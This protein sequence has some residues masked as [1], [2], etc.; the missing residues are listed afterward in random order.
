M[1][2]IRDDTPR[3][4]GHRPKR[5][6]WYRCKVGEPVH[7]DVVAFG[8]QLLTNE[9]T[10]HQQNLARERIYEGRSLAR[11]REGL[12]LLERSGNSVARL[13][14]LKSIIDTFTSRLAKDR[15][16][17]SFV[18]DD[19]EWALKRKA[20]Q[21]RKFIVGQ[22]LETEFDS[23]SVV[24]LLDGGILGSAF[25]RI[26]DC[27]DSVLAER[28]HINEILF[29]RREC[30]YGK[31]QQAMRIKRV[32]RDYLC[33]LFPDHEE[34]IEHAAPA[35]RR[36]GSSD[37]DGNA[38]G[39]LDDYVDTWEAWHLP[40]TCESENGRHALC[41]E[42][43]TLVSEEWHEPR[44]PWAMFTLFRAQHGLYGNG[45]VDQL[46]ELQHRVN[47]IVRDIQLNLAATGRGHFLVNA[48][49]DMP[50]E[51]LSGFQPFKMK[52]NGPTPPIW[53]A[54]QAYS[55][56]Q[57]SALDRF[58]QA[59]YDLSGVSQA[60][61]TS[62]SALGA[63]ASGV[64]LDTQYD[65]DSDRFRLPQKNYADYRLSGAQRYLDAA[66][67]VARHRESE[68][69]KKRSYVGVSWKNRD[70]IERLEYSKVALKD[71]EYRLQI[72]PVNFIPDTRSGKLSIVEQLL[73]AGVY[74]A[75]LAPTLFDEPDLQQAN[76]ILLASFHRSMQKMDELAD[77]DM[78]IPVPESYNDLDLEMKIANAYY[79]RVQTDR[80]PE[81]IQ[82]RYRQYMDLLAGAIK[83]KSSG[84]G[85][86]AAP[87]M[88]APMPGA[89]GPDGM[90]MAPA[91]LPLPGGI[92][93]MPTGPVPPPMP[94]GAQSPPPPP[95]VM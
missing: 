29:D 27:D 90:P 67:R 28:M 91:E 5:Q 81:G 69:G 59:M 9:S 26:D 64:A 46:A 44:F 36:N 41:I 16:M 48:A 30:E 89:I 35:R 42:G 58:I 68:K 14:A 87:P 63:G 55:P 71:D 51:M 17:P 11:Y 93:L 78:P 94:I 45:F 12:S 83:Q 43:A 19:A 56:A 72:E 37:H 8:E 73:K 85:G 31:P 74:P 39:D 7:Q 70:A 47:L 33:E 61:A 49:N 32:A 23:L 57:M 25:T 34:A 82:D 53:T 95:M 84:A 86:G 50:V 52:Y 80:A 54:P 13:N 22:M 1:A 18:V 77:E 62:K 15:P 65:I 20:K 24:A 92:P 38:L 75:W 4:K 21:Y 88:P 76:A 60:S 3:Q 6:H 66:K 40:T 79:H 10:F 2:I